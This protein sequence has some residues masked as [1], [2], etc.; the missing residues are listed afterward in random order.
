[1][2]RMRL[3]PRRPQERLRTRPSLACLVRVEQVGVGI[4]KRD[5]VGEIKIPLHR[6]ATPLTVVDAER[7][8]FLCDAA[9]LTGV[10]EFRRACG[11]AVYLPASTF[12]QTG[13]DLHK[14]PW[15]TTLDAPT[16]A[17]LPRLVGDLLQQKRTPLTNDLMRQAAMQAF[18]MGGKS[19]LPIRKPRLRAAATLPIRK[20][21]R[22]ITESAAGQIGWKGQPA[23]DDPIAPPDQAGLI[24]LPFHRVQLVLALEA[25]PLGVAHSH[26]HHRPVGAASQLLAHRR[27]Q[28]LLNPAGGMTALLR[29]G[30]ERRIPKAVGCPRR[31]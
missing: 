19:S 29:I 28:M 10:G 4:Q 23:P 6:D 15:R 8:W 17:T 24:A 3:L 7:E 26:P 22:R 2:S 11:D 9:T 13:Q 21:Q 30:L 16:K 27:V 18:A 5:Q 14:H 31:C 25:H 1:M 20:R 12:S